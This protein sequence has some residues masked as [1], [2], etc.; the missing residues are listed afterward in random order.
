MDQFFTA[1]FGGFK[2]AVSTD[3]YGNR[4]DSLP[5]VGLPVPFW[6]YWTSP[7]IV[8]IKKTIYHSWLG[9]VTHEDI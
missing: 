2:D 8:A 3:F 5:G 9:D 1:F 6:E 4:R 7:E